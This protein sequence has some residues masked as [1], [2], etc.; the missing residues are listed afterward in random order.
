M[1]RAKTLDKRMLE[2]ASQKSL[3]VPSD[4]T[5][6]AVSG[7][8]DS[9]ALCH[10]FYRN[11]FSFGIAHCNFQLR[12]KESDKDEAFVKKLAED[13]NVPFHS[14][15]FDTKKFARKNKESIQL[16]AR[17]L[18]YE[19]LFKLAMDEN[20]TRLASA[21]HLDDSVETILYNFA[22]GCGIRGLHGILPQSRNLIRPLLFATKDEILAYVVSEGLEFREDA[23]NE[24]DKYT[25][26][27][28]RHHVVPVLTELN[29]SFLSTA[30]DT[31]TRL[32]EAE[33]LYDFA[34]SHIKEEICTLKDGTLLFDIQKM[35]M[36][37]ALPTILYEL[38]KEFGFNNVQ[39]SQI[40][41]SMYGQPGKIFLAGSW[42]LVVDRENL[43]LTADADNPQSF[44]INDLDSSPLYLPDGRLSFH[45]TERIP[46]PVP[47]DP[48]SA[49]MDDEKVKFPFTLRHWKEGD[50]FQ[51]LGMHGKHQKLQDFF[52][53]QK[54]SI[55]D[56]EKIW[57]LESEGNICWVAGLRIDERVKLSSSTRKC[58]VA[59]YEPLTFV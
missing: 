42:R 38:L 57:L 59:V 4:R 6:L 15:R 48:Y 7:G 27:I 34:L 55:P 10:L 58:L 52:T 45:I 40:S 8:I 3:L 36:Y 33:A 44:Y 13:M 2:Y 51:P 18:R 49:W 54:I 25:R 43:V 32:R 50:V 9:V 56:K 31:I 20:Y 11:K 23:S 35:R 21:H 22:K 14:I 5:L 12:G 37:P 30:N 41:E 19:W 24:S 26:N 1:T 28:I 46:D 17:N 16:T 53:H 39:T 29:P 47:S